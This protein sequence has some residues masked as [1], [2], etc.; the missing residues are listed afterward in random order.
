MSLFTSEKQAQ[1]GALSLLVA[2]RVRDFFKIEANRTEFE[3]LSN[4]R[5]VVKEVLEG[6]E[7]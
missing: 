3:N 5:D 2:Q 6:G 1:A 7:K 4:L